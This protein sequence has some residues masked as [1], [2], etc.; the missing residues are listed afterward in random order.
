M[1]EISSRSNVV[2]EIKKLNIDELDSDIGELS[3]IATEL[4]EDIAELE[5]KNSQDETED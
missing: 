1:S 2:E 4:R 3:E 5:A